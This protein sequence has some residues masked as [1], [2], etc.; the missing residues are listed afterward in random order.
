VKG[1]LHT[2]QVFSGRSRLWVP[3]GIMAPDIS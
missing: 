1:R 2:R 3:L